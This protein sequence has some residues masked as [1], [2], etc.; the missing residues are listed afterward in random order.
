MPANHQNWCK[1]TE[2]FVWVGFRFICE[3]YYWHRI[4]HNSQALRRIFSDRSCNG[5][6]HAQNREQRAHRMRSEFISEHGKTL[7]EWKIHNFVRAL[8]PLYITHT[9]K[10]IFLP[11]CTQTME[12]D[13]RKHANCVEMRYTDITLQNTYT[14][15]WIIYRIF[16]LLLAILAISVPF[17]R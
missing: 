7:F 12:R 16:L 9:H 17:V 6:I 15:T 3:W 1:Q 4:G 5:S 14:Y 2:C 8:R 11:F 13:E 10:R